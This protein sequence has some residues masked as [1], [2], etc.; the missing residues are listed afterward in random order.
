MTRGK[1]V[2]VLLFGLAPMTGP[3]HEGTQGWDVQPRTVRRSC[4]QRPGTGAEAGRCRRGWAMQ[5]SFEL[6]QVAGAGGDERV[7][8]RLS[9]DS[10]GFWGERVT[11][12]QNR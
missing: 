1:Q 9:S 6:R 11:D 7:G 10:V 5:F 4:F 12:G 3:R 2:Q 8:G